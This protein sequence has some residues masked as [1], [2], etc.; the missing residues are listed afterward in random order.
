MLKKNFEVNGIDCLEDNFFD[1][2]II[3]S[4]QQTKEIHKRSLSKNINLR[5]IDEEYIGISLDETTS[6]KDIE[7]VLEIFT[8]QKIDSNLKFE[9]SIPEKLKRTSSF[10]DHEVFKRYRTETEL[11]RYIRKLSDKDI[12]LDRAMI[13]LGSC[14]M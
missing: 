9:S 2:L 3:R 11:V 4:G 10:L 14:T 6:M 1:T 13:P 5:R 7:N 8:N 12:A